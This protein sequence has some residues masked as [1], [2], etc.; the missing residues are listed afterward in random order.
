MEAKPMG[1][2][3]MEARSAAAKPA[4]ARPAEARPTEARP[5]EAR[6]AVAR[7]SQSKGTDTSLTEDSA[8]DEFESS[9]R[10]LTPPEPVK[11]P[12][13][14][15][16]VEL[17]A[18]AGRLRSEEP[19]VVMDDAPRFASRNWRAEAWEREREREQRSVNQHG[20]LSPRRRS[21]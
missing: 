1:T 21:S 14:R 13:L 17:V 19:V 10:L 2:R 18:V 16:T 20:G 4:E 8:Y 9:A 6:V 3:L 11:R 12:V 5:V 15:P 7:A